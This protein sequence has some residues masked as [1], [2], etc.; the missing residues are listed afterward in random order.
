MAVTRPSLVRASHV[1]VVGMGWGPRWLADE[2][3]LMEM[4]SSNR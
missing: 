2:D 3:R 4:R 1:I